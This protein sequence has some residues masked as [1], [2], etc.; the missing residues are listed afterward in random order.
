MEVSWQYSTAPCPLPAVPTAPWPTQAESSPGRGIRK[1]HERQV[2][3]AAWDRLS[4][5]RAVLKQMH[6]Q[7]RTEGRVQ[8]KATGREPPEA[9]DQKCPWKEHILSKA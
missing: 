3:K 6:Y 5:T 8:G 7:E 2:V 9:A 4:E 1:R